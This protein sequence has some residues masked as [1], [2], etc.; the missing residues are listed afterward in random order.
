MVAAV[1][2]TVQVSGDSRYQGRLDQSVVNDITQLNPVQVARV[3]TPR[4][5]EE[6]VAA[7]RSSSGPISIGGGRFSMGGQ[8]AREGTL[9]LDMRQYDKVVA[10]SPEKREITVESGITWR[11]IQ[12]RI[13]PHGL[14]VKIMQTY[15]DFTVGGSLSVNVHGRYIGHGPLISSVKAIGLVLADGSR[16]EATPRKN[17]E[18]FYSAI[19]GYGGIG[20]ITEVTLMLDKNDKVERRTT[21]MTASQYRDYFRKNIRD[22]DKVVFQNADLYPPAFENVRDVS[23]YITDKPLTLDER[24]IPADRTYFWL[25]R[26][27]A[28]VSGSSF[29][30]WTREHVF[31]PVYYAFDRVVWRNWEA[32]Y[33]V[34]ELGGEDRSK[35]TYVL[36]E[37]FIPV[38]RF[39][40]FVPKMRAVFQAHDVDVLNVS[41]RHAKPDPGS[42]L[43]WAREEVFAFVVY[44]AQGTSAKDQEKVGQWTR[45]MID[46]IL[47]AGGTYYLPYQPHATQEQFRK[48]Y[49]RAE[50]FFAVK[51]KVDPH[52]RFQNK[53]WEKYYPSRTQQIGAFLAQHKHYRRG[54]E[55]SFLSLPE[56]YL[57][58]NPNEYADYLNSGRNPSDFPFFRSIDE[59]WTLYDRVTALTHGVYPE[60]SEY[61]T[62]LWVIG[63]ST[64]AEYLL[65]GVYENTVGRLT[66]WTASGETP[67]DLL[68]RRAHQAYAIF[69]F[70][71]PWYKFPFWSWTER[72][73]T[74]TPTGGANLI[75]KFERK[76]FFTLE[77]AFKA[78]YAKLIGFGATTAYEPSDGLV[79]MRVKADPRNL[80]GIDQR[81]QVLRDFGGRELVVTLPRWGAFTEIVPKM[82]LA[83]VEFVEISGNDDIMVSATAAL[84]ASPE[85]LPMKLLFP[86]TVMS[87]DNRK[88]LVFVA[89]V[90]NLALALREIPKAQMKLEHIYDF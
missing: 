10:F 37:Y 41:I 3:I 51:R 70:D 33:D 77:F 13:D 48:A 53:L 59:Y 7:V 14:A 80:A 85:G 63:V 60:N 23:W 4:S 86:S 11:Q 46:A 73:W 88:R 34:R 52:N 68:M 57:V 81:I 19:G 47:S 65:K 79:T 36:Q 76:M 49:P 89:K 25:P 50:A 28:F 55:Q 9:H 61:Q 54:E 84:D 35:K 75:R 15:S 32:S 18:L 66:L 67:E 42:Y 31:D 29:G 69:I 56:W 20:V 64:T 74:E 87:P 8:T 58:F 5:I 40:E 72:I 39:D 78:L 6:I 22:N 44:Y 12:H 90:A 62:M 2:V 43:A 27:A 1:T 30:K 17:P 38:D 16:V 83:G 71:E 24:L 82:A 21:T 45:E 26:L